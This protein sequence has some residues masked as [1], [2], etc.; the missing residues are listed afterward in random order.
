MFR[1]PNVNDDVRISASSSLDE[2]T[3]SGI[4]TVKSLEVT[5]GQLIIAPSAQMEV[6][7]QCLLTSET[8][9]VYGRLV[10]G[11]LIWSG[12][13]LYGAQSSGSH[14]GTIVSQLMLVQRGSSDSKK[15]YDINIQIE[16]N[17]TV[18]SEFENSAQLTC[19]NCRL[20]NAAN[21]TMTFT[22]LSLFYATTSSE[23]DASTVDGFRRGLIN[24]GTVVVILFNGS[25][26]WRWDVRNFGRMTFV[27]I[28]FRNSRSIEFYYNVFANWGAVESFGSRVCVP[29]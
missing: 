29:E 1:I 20:V 5:D 25:P 9:S 28:N 19:G 2:I 26:N 16:K 27:N 18:D 23:R 11:E 7:N 4:V 10:V 14:P 15:L 6:T 22:G 17:F 24:N 13:S 12:A 3:V 8:V 21:S